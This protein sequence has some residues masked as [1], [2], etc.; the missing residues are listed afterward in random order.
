MKIK[1][2]KLDKAKL[3][4]TAGEILGII[5]GTIFMAFS[6]VLFLIPHRLA[7][8]GASGLAVIIFYLFKLPVGVSI[9]L[10]NVPLFIAAYFFLGPQVVVRSLL[11]TLIFSAVSELVSLY[12]PL[13]ATGDILLA[14]VYGGILMGIGIGIVFRSR[15]STGG[16][17]LISLILHRLI[18]LSTGQGI[19]YSDLVIIALGLFAFG[20]EV[21]MY[22]ALSLFVS[23]YVI[24]VVQ[25]G[26]GLAKSVLIIT[27]RGQVIADRLLV[28]LNRGVT[29]LSGRGAYTG[30]PREL[31]LCVVNRLQVAQLKT[32]V[33]EGDPE[34]FFIIGSANEVHGEGFRRLSP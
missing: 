28:E 2:P 6:L 26:L 12:L 20:G 3:K 15:G 1:L 7:A 19:L 16:T 24:D 21:A 27:S 30:E 10:I 8:G 25:E 11:G 18:G 32:I 9:L 13:V 34:A 14:A 31:L 29:R 22:A 33:Q 23:T 5:I 4:K 17:S